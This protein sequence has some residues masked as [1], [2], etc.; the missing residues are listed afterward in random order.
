MLTLHARAMVTGF[1]SCALTFDG[2]TIRGMFRNADELQQD[3]AGQFVQIADCG[4]RSMSEDLA[5]IERGARVTVVRDD[6]GETTAT[7]YKVDAKLKVSDAAHSV[8]V[9][10]RVR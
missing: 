3:S 5:A 1:G 4:F 9:L 6:L 2:R 8:L 7:P 10:S